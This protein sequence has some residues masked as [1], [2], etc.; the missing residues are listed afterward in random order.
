MSVGDEHSI[1]AAIAGS[2][3]SAVYAVWSFHACNNDA[4]TAALA[5]LSG[6]VSLSEGVGA[7]FLENNFVTH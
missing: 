4:F 7:F 6:Q 1:N 2:A 5:Q 3:A